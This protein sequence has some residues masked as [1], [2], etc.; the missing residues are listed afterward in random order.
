[1]PGLIGMGGT[2]ADAGGA[3]IGIGLPPGAAGG[4]LFAVI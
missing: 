3:S 4:I 2:E 1:V